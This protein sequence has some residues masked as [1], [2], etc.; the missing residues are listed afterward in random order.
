[1]TDSRDTGPRHLR[2]LGTRGIPA[3]YGGFETSAQQIALYLV[4][5]GWKVTVYCEG[6]KGSKPHEDEW[7]DVHRVHVPARF[8]GPL[9]SVLFDLES[10]LHAVVRDG[11]I[12]TLGYN[13]GIFF[14]IY[15][16]FGRRNLVNMDGLEW[17]RS[18]WSRPVQLWLRLNERLACLLG[19]HLIADHPEIEVHL[20]RYAPARKISMVT[21]SAK[22]VTTADPTLLY[23]LGLEPGRFILVVARPD[24]DNSPL[25]IV[26]AYSRRPRGIPLVM[27]GAFDPAH[28][29]D[30]ARVIEAA[31]DEV[32]FVGAIYDPQLLASL[33]FHALAYLHGH[34]RGGVNPSLV[35]SMAAGT[36]VLALDNVFNRWT[37]GD[38]AHYFSTVDELDSHLT[39]I[40]SDPGMRDRMREAG[41]RRFGE[42]FTEEIVLGAY[43]KLF[44]DWIG[45]A[46]AA[47]SAMHTG[48][49]SRPDGIGA[50]HRDD[51]DLDGPARSLATEPGRRDG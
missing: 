1:M 50:R 41:K 30:H 2:I 16:L 28:S 49:S 19:N 45:D 13:T 15:R 18:K 10:T 35:E 44:L 38:A 25:E 43:E 40:A 29:A 14:A 22:P 12:L 17:M 20:R 9:G 47:L 36:P 21:Y 23:R 34:Q 51:P 32:K 42:A 27:L 26:T 5:R 4:A 7:C 39:S 48:E 24:P 33:R 31:G 8:S 3:S 37:A 11:L 6:P 46:P